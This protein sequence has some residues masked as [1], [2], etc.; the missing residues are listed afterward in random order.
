[1][2]EIKDAMPFAISSSTN[3]V[4]VNG[5]TTFG[6]EYPF[7]TIDI[8]NSEHS[9]FLKLRS[10]LVLL[11]Q[12]LREIT[13]DVHY[14]NFRTVRLANGH[15]ANDSGSISNSFY[16]DEKDKKLR[17]KEQEIRKMQEILQKMQM[18]MQ[19]KAEP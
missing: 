4:E 8:M 1:M 2:N 19:L 3:K 13:I 15:G 16:E 11:M 9:D 18:E 14:E 10:M 12:D 17:E 7:G 5:K 6:R